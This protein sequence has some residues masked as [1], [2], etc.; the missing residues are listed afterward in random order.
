[1]DTSNYKVNKI[2]TKIQTNT[3]ALLFSLYPTP[4][5]PSLTIFRYIPSFMFL[6]LPSSYEN[7]K[8][9]SGSKSGFSINVKDTFTLNTFTSSNSLNWRVS[10]IHYFRK[11]THSNGKN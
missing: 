11:V 5:M 2:S 6:I 1:M 3:T 9:T 10:K 4:H 8:D 7:T